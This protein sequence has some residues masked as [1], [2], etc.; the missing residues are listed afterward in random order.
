MSRSQR[1]GHFYKCPICFDERWVFADLMGRKS[2]ACPRCTRRAE[3]EWKTVQQV[4]PP[5]AA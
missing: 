1:S 5:T 2:D 3:Q 4:M